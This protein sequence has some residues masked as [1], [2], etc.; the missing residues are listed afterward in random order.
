[1]SQ[2]KERWEDSGSAAIT[3]PST[4]CGF[5]YICFYFFLFDLA[6]KSGFIKTRNATLLVRCKAKL[7]SQ[8]IYLLSYLIAPDREKSI[9]N[10]LL[11]LLMFSNEIKK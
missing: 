1:M 10:L 8:S 4:E 11:P 3:N 5:I 6:E 2:G 7:V 9:I